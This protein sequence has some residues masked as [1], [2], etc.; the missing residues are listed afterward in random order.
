MITRLPRAERAAATVAGVQCC[1]MRD[2]FV[3]H[4]FVQFNSVIVHEARDFLGEALPRADAR[5]LARRSDRNQLRSA[6][7]AFAG[8][9]WV[10]G[11]GK[12]SFAIDLIAPS[13][14][15]ETAPPRSIT[16]GLNA[17]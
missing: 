3:C 10:P 9:P 4:S 16:N 5:R 2:L 7:W 11:L 8:L 14:L 17:R 6:M 1:I 12:S 15:S 13:D